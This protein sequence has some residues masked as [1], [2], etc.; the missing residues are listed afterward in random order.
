MQCPKFLVRLA[1]VTPASPDR[2]GDERMLGVPRRPRR[3]LVGRFIDNRL[4]RFLLVGGFNVVQGVFWFALFHEIVGGALPYL[5]ILMLAYVPAILVGFALYR[6]FVFRVAG[7]VLADFTRFTM[8]QGTAFLINVVSLPFLHEVIGVPLL[9]AQALS[10]GVILVFNY[11]GHLYF[12]FRRSH[13]HPDAGAVFEPE[14]LAD[15]DESRTA[16]GR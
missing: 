3:G 12:S 4:F 2:E 7:H 5:V 14:V 9:L 10:V 1:T 8:V 16:P 6:S 15:E 11:V 13:G